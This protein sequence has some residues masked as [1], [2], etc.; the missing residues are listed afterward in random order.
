MRYRTPI[1]ALASAL[2]IVAAAAPLALASSH[3]EAPGT[4]KDRLADDTDLYAWV[5][6]DAQGAVTIAGNWVPLI[7][8][9]S[10]PNFA[11]FDDD[12]SYYINIDNV[13]DA[14]QHLRY[15]FEFQTTRNGDTFLYNNGEV[16]SLDDENLL[17]RQTYTVTR[18]EDHK[19]A[20]TWGPFPVAPSY[21][22]PTSMPRYGDLAQSA[23]QTLPDGTRI[24]VGPRDDPFYVDLAEVFD[25]LRIR[26]GLGNTGGGVDGVGGFD[27]MSIVIQ[28]P[29]RRLTRDGRDPD[30]GRHNHIIGIWDTA[31]RRKARILEPDGGV[32]L[33][34]PEVQVSRLG[35]PLVNELIIPLKDKDRFNASDPADDAQFLG[36]VLDPEPARLLHALY[37]LTVPPTPRNDLVSVFLTGIPGLNQPDHVRPAEMLRLNLIIAPGTTKDRFG[38]IAGDN[39]GFP[40][41]RRLTD[42]VV[43]IVERAAAGGDVLTPATNVFP[44]NVLGDGVDANDLPFLPYFPYVAPPHN[45]VDHQHHRLEPVTAPAGPSIGSLAPAA[46]AAGA[47]SVPARAANLVLAGANPGRTGVLQYT[48]PSAARVSVRVYDVQGRSVRTLVDQDAAAGTFR[49]SWNGLTDAGASAGKGVF[50]ARL[51]AAGR[52]VDTKKLVIE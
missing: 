18:I 41:G 9:N 37:G 35:M 5:A 49:A 17:V 38:V 39:A 1:A 48:L 43:D 40:N 12:A 34:G 11:S 32:K 21:V 15:E 28:V 19:R 31:E 3:S 2:L 14:R 51:V 52:V 4:S 10:G 20:G 8:P 22:G 27:V 16:T 47:E 30:P 6:D 24:F 33:E 45:P 42:D 7:E 36:Y 26:H 46:P 23:I 13:G 50:F 25:L 44:N 29:K